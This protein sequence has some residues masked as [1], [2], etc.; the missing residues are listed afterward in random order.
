[1]MDKNNNAAELQRIKSLMNYGINESKQPEY[2]SV[3]YG[4]VAADGK[5]YG[6]VREG[7]H[8][9]IKV[10]KNPKGSLISENFDYIGGFRNRKN[11]QFESFAS[12]QR[13][14]GEKLICINESIDDVQKRVITEAWDIDAKKEV[15]EEGT[16]RMQSEIARQRQI[17]MNAQNIT[18]GK[19]QNCCDPVIGKDA[20]KNAEAPKCDA[21]KAECATDYHGNKI[22]SSPSAPFVTPGKATGDKDPKKPTNESTETPLS[23]RE[24]PDYMDKSCGTEIGKN[25]GFG[26]DVEK[27]ENAVADAE[28]GEAEKTQTTVN[29][30]ESMH[31]AE[32]QNT[33]AVG[34]ADKGDTAPFD[35][36]ANVNESLD[37]LDDNLD[38]EDD[39]SE[40]E[41]EDIDFDTELAQ[42]D[43]D[44]LDDTEDGV[45]DDTE[46]PLEDVEGAADNDLSA[47]MDAIESKIDALLSAINNMKYDDDEPLYDDEEEGEDVED[48]EGDTEDTPAEDIE[49]PAETPEVEDEDEENVFESKSYKAM[50]KMN[51]DRLNDFGKHPAYQKKVMTLPAN[52]NPK[53]DGQYDMNDESVD[54]EQ[55]YGQKKGDNAPF[56]KVAEKD[57]DA[58]TEA[59]MKLLKKKLA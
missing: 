38:D 58:I 28:G 51:E 53:A 13:S 26:V 45:V 59:V 2:S 50:K 29:E 22:P 21:K 27:A 48:V 46:D 30:E 47:R 24:N 56:T 31:D 8:Y 10:A 35:E 55:P 37:D 43:E 6:I 15:V 5:L 4:K 18:E 32:N 19:G 34:T 17:M 12:A 39:F 41:D 36:K 9:F 3:E 33:P 25:S 14:L 42:D 54:G 49:A 44:G 20:K 11:H 40:D 57:V 23:S 7:T 52:T 1:M 16:K